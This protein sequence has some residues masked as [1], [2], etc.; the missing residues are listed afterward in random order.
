MA[1]RRSQG[2]RV[3]LA[4]PNPMVE[5]DTVIQVNHCRMPDCDNI[6]VPAKTTPVKTG[7]SSDRDR[8]LHYTLS[9]T[10]KGRVAA[11][12][13]KCCGEKPPLKSNQGIAEELARISAHYRVLTGDAPRRTVKIM[14]KA[15]RSIRA[16]TTSAGRIRV[17]VARGTAV[18]PAAHAF[19]AAWNRPEFTRNT[20]TWPQPSSVGW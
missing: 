13:C 16:C 18:N 11:L 5:S 20:I 7:R 2:V 12:K 15:Q 10:G 1:Y 14:A 4:E 8:D 9:N 6:G 19:K 3:P 17:T